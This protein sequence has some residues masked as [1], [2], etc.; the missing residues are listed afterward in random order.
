MVD[1]I[2]FVMTPYQDCKIYGPYLRKDGR[3]HV[4]VFHNGKRLATVSY[5]K[6]IVEMAIGRYLTWPETVHHIDDDFT[7]NSL[8]NLCIMNI[9]DHAK[10]HKPK[11]YSGG[12]YTC[13]GCGNKFYMSRTREMDRARN[14]NRGRHGPFCSKA[15]SGRYGRKIQSARRETA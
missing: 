3:S 15:C 7:N 11:Q 2:D 12:Y 6:Y 10:L 5:P 14:K 4:I 9:S 8:D 13:V 1:T